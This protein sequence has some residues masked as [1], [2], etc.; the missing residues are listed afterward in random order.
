MLVAGEN[1]RFR[2][3]LLEPAARRAIPDHE[4]P[5]PNPALLQRGN[6]FGKDV[7]ALLHDNSAEEGDH[8]LPVGYA[9]RA[10][11]IHVAPLRI[12]LVAIDAARPHRDEL[13]HPLRA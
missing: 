12:E 1:G 9:E 7:E 5:V 13:V 4:N 10:S 11:P 6:G 8:H 2:Q 3:V